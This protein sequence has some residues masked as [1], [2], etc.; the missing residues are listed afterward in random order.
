ML[1]S[2]PKVKS[3]GQMLQKKLNWFLKN[4]GLKKI[5]HIYIGT[6]FQQVNNT[7]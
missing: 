4:N 6:P 5:K 3:Q 2:N 7:S 1:I